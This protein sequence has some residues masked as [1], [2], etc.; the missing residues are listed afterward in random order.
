MTA[1]SLVDPDS[2]A[3]VG[4]VALS[5]RVRCT[6][7]IGSV[8]PPRSATT[9]RCG[10]IPTTPAAWLRDIVCPPL[11]LQYAVLGCRGARATCGPTG[12]RGR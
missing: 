4:T 5:R 10:S 1:D 6:G 11:Y 7:V 2:A 3:K 12:P 9:T 8:G